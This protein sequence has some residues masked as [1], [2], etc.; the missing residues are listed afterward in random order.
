MSHLEVT[1][2][3]SFSVFVTTDIATLVS[4]SSHALLLYC[5]CPVGLP[6]TTADP[7]L[8]SVLLLPA[9]LLT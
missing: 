9:L 2:M 1:T 4:S 5:Y 8:L 3:I 7:V 6:L